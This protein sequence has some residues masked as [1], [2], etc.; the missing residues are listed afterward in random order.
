MTFVPS[1][2]VMVEFSPPSIPFNFMLLSSGVNFPTVSLSIR[3]PKPSEILIYFIFDQCLFV[4]HLCANFAY[5][6][7]RSQLHSESLYLFTA[8]S[9]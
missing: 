1:L 2:S 3:D 5:V 9:L 4:V 8:N 6:D 7:I